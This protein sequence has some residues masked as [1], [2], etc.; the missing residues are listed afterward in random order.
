M[1]DRKRRLEQF[2]FYNCAGIERRLEKMAAQGWMLDEIGPFF[3]S[4]RRIEP[5][6][7][8]FSVCYFLEASEYDP[9]P[10]EGQKTFYDFC[11]HTGWTLAASSAQMQVFYNEQKNPVPIE[12]DPVVAVD[13]IHRMAKSRFLPYNLTVMAVLLMY[14]WLLAELWSSDPVNVLADGS[15]FWG[16]IALLGLF[17]VCA[18]DVGR[19]ELWHIRAKKAAEWGELLPVPSCARVEWIIRLWIVASLTA[20]L[21]S[22]PGLT[23]AVIGVRA[24]GICAIAFLIYSGRQLF[25]R[26]KK[27]AKTSRTVAHAAC[28]TLSFVVMTAAVCL[29]QEGRNRNWFGDGC[30]TYEHNGQSYVFHQD[31]LPLTV[32]DLVDSDY[33]LYCRERQE[34]SSPLA[35]RTV[36]RQGPRFD[37]EDY[38]EI[39]SLTYIVVR[40]RLPFLSGLCW[41]GQYRRWDDQRRVD[42]SH[43][44]LYEPMD[45]AP[46][47]AEEAY[48]QLYRDGGRSNRYLL[49]YEGRVVELVFDFGEDGPTPAQMAVVGERLGS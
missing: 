44:K 33:G 4:Y 2:P 43:R 38:D 11:A 30:G 20:S 9:E 3:W 29:E 6:K 19:Y 12:T 16:G 28:F 18:L 24:V 32:E 8:T 41:E 45:P 40:P 17:A 48:R 7:L 26:R 10:S 27:P 35:V 39:P 42:D 31:A 13:S 34:K 49:R 15:L 36:G 5:Q 1:K 37:E 14:G 21:L 46:W 25:K 23:A 22:V 47:G